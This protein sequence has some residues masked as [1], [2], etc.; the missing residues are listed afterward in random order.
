MYKAQQI[1]NNGGDVILITLTK[2]LSGFMQTGKACSSYRLF[3]HALWKHYGCPSADYVIVDEVQDFEKE[4]IEEFI[5]AA[6]KSFFFFGDSAQS[7]YNQYGRNTLSI[8]EISDMTGLKPLRL[9]NNYRLPRSVAKITQA[10]VGVVLI[11]M[12][13]R[14]TRIKKKHCPILY[15]MKIMMHRFWHW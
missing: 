14:C 3:H 13:R 10:Y 1:A 6:R 11:L 9:Y 12:R 7:I 15:I 2:S 5:G 4:D 8:E